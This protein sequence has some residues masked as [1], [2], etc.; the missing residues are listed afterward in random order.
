M[1][2]EDGLSKHS[3]VRTL[4]QSL[5]GLFFISFL[6]VANA[7]QEG[8]WKPLFS[9]TNL[10][11]LYIH[12][13]GGK[14]KNEDPDHLVQIH[15]GMIHMYKDAEQGS[16]QAAG[17]IST[18]KEYADYHLR[19]QYKWG[20]KRFGG[21]VNSKRDAGV[22]YHMF[23]ADNVWPSGVECQVQE[24]D[25]GD[26]F[27][28]NTR[29]TTTVNPKT[30]NF[31]TVLSTNAAGVIAGNKTTRPQFLEPKAGGIPY[32]QG[33]SN[34]I[35]RVIRCEMLE[36]DGWN[37]VEV[38]VRGDSGTHIINGKANNRADQ[39]QRLVQG[40]WVPLTKG[41]IIFQLEFAEVMYRNI[42]IRSLQ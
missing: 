17:Y 20:D 27:T 4:V 37:T 18:E 8:N 16:K 5:V 29:V 31:V 6:S 30:T 22:I 28:V 9:G 14:K 34:S 3:W 23:G 19:F 42:E 13:G 32:T 35:R 12:L 15:D 26:I 1:T 33:V 11:G 7:A 21:R 24:G 25:V 36:K 41:K 10:D 40:E 2:N 38:I 39:V